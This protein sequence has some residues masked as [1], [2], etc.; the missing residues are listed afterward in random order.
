MEN[1][2][3]ASERDVSRIAEIL[4]FSKRVNYRPIFENDTV[5]FGEMQVC[6][7]A[8]ELLRDPAVLH[9]YWVY[10]DGIV[11]G[12]VRLEGDEIRELYVEPF[13][14]GGGIGAWLLRF[15]AEEKGC[16]WLWVL[17][18]NLRAIR[19]YRRNGFE[20]TGVRRIQPG[21]TETVIRLE[22]TAAAPVSPD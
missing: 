8:E 10:D 16:R 17:E 6:P 19:F 7:L 12:L 18:K 1:I 9:H 20:P 22:R 5:S 13:F 11:K 15:A 14:T 2:R 21:T 4:I 3:Q